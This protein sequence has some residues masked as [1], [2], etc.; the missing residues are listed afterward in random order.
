VIAS[1]SLMPWR[2]GLRLPPRLVSDLP[3]R[4]VAGLP[5]I[6]REF[7]VAASL[8]LAGGGIRTRGSLIA[9]FEHASNPERFVCARDTHPRGH[10]V[11]TLE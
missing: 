6:A 3:A 2:F 11:A 4:F 7:E 1:L 10:L 8:S 5:E 9:S